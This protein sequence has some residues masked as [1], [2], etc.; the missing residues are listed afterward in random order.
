MKN[1]TVDGV[2]F[3]MSSTLIS[4]NS[5][6]SLIMSIEYPFPPTLSLR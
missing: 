5:K 6:G 3:K 2:D 4:N 1:L